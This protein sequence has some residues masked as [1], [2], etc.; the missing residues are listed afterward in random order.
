M[1]VALPLRLAAAAAGLV[2][3][4]AAGAVSATRPA[5]KPP[6]SA[7]RLGVAAPPA[8]TDP[9]G[10]VYLEEGFENDL[11]HALSGRLKTP[12]EIVRLSPDEAEA[13][14]RD[15]RVD[16][17]IARAGP[18]AASRRDVKVIPAGYASGVGAALRSDTDIHAWS[19]LR[20][21]TACVSEANAAGRRLAEDH[22]ARLRLTSAP[23]PA[24]IDLRT[25]LCDVSIHDAAQLKPLL[26]KR[27]WRKF[28]STLPE[29]APT[30]L[31]VL[32]SARQPDLAE[33]AAEATAAIAGGAGGDTRAAS[34]ASMV[35][36]EVYRD[37]V[38]A[39]CH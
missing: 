4:V 26:S 12:A 10:R 15:G 2:A 30:S 13:A 6:V 7:V 18:D 9:A 38:A 24:L 19:D 11:A 31:A 20:G 5:P 32:V 37:Q 1:A 39:D 33:W 34:W 36:F 28:S 16:L 23:A 22:G 21:R 27:I 25:G 29:V 35:D 17:L 3:L 14:L 8:P